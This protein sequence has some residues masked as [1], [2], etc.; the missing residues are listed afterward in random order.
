MCEEQNNFA[1]SPFPSI[2]GEFSIYV[3]PCTPAERDSALG[4]V[5]TCDKGEPNGET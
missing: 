3:P 4:N 1:T 5:G 2:S